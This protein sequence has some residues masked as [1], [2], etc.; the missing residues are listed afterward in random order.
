MKLYITN[1]DGEIPDFLTVSPLRGNCVRNIDND[2][3]AN[4]ECDEIVVDCIDYIPVTYL[5]SSIQNYVQKLAKRG[6]ITIKGQDVYLLALNITK[7]N[8]DIGQINYLIYGGPT[9]DKLKMSI[10]SVQELT[11]ILES[12][13]IKITKKQIDGINY[14]IEGVK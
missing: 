6:K 5:Y 10:V 12:L 7:R 3:A 4:S 9:A 2:I 14:I 11:A 8:L 13:K 1:S